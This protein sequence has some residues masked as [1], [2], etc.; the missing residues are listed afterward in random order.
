MTR[1]TADYRLRI[2]GL[3]QPPGTIPFRVLVTLLD[4]LRQTAERAT[5]LLATG[6][7]RSAGPPPAWLR[8]VV[9]LE[10]RG[11]GQGSTTVDLAAPTLGSVPGGPFSSGLLWGDQPDLGDTALDIAS[12]AIAEARDPA[13]TG[14][15]FDHAVL[16]AATTLASALP[17]EGVTWRLEAQDPRHASITIEPGTAEAIR[18]RTKEIPGP[19]TQVITGHLDEIAHR[20]GQFRLH[21][22]PNAVLR[23]NVNRNALDVESLR[24]LWGREATVTGVVHFKLDGTPRRIEA[25]RITA[26]HDGDAVFRRLPLESGRRKLLLP[27]RSEAGRAS[28]QLP[29]F[30]QEWPGEETLEELLA[31][32]D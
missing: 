13:A 15:R 22:P 17:E 28:G 4:A 18:E 6:S 3:S 10:L 31:D 5:R 16:D 25:H 26:S 14:E 24:G 23:G 8:A 29:S 2:E 9:D 27:R 1:A 30:D 20:R 12:R 19:K 11:L 7:G 32:L 21:V